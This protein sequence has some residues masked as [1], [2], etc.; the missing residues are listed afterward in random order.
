[1]LMWKIKVSKFADFIDIAT[2]SVVV[3]PKKLPVPVQ[4]AA[5]HMKG[6]ELNADLFLLVSHPKTLKRQSVDAARHY[7]GIAR[8]YG[9]TASHTQEEMVR[10]RVSESH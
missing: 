1:M 7:L 10:G 6:L 2:P 5:M 4:F 8:M 3:L 9:Q